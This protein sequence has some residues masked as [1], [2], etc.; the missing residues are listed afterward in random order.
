[1][2]SQSDQYKKDN[3]KT[4]IIMKKGKLVAR[5][6]AL[7]IFFMLYGITVSQA[8]ETYIYDLQVIYCGFFDTPIP[9]YAKD[10]DGVWDLNKGAGG[11][12]IALR[13]KTTDD[14]KN[15]ITDIIVVMEENTT[16]Y[17]GTQNKTIIIDGK[18]YY[19]APYVDNTDGGNLNK[20]VDDCKKNL[21]LYYT[22]DGQVNDKNSIVPGS[23]ALQGLKLVISDSR[24]D[25]TGSY[26]K[27]YDAASQSLTVGN[28]DCNEGAGG[29]FIYIETNYHNHKDVGEKD[30]ITLCD[31]GY[32]PEKFKEPELE[33]GCYKI[34][35][36]WELIWLQD[37]YNEGEINE[38]FN[39]VMTADIDMS[40]SDY[41]RG[42]HVLGVI[43]PFNE[44]KKRVWRG[45][46][47]GNGHKISGSHSALFG[48]AGGVV[49]NLFMEN[50]NIHCEYAAAIAY[51][52]IGEL[53]IKGC[54]VSGVVTG[55]RIVSGFV[56]VTGGECKVNISLSENAAQIIWDRTIYWYL[57]TC[58]FVGST[59]TY[60]GI[61]EKVEVNLDRCINSGKSD[62]AFARRPI[63]KITNCLNVSKSPFM[64]IYDEDLLEVKNCLN[65]AYDHFLFECEYPLAP[66]PIEDKIPATCYIRQTTGDAMPG[67][68][69]EQQ[70][71]NGEAC[72][73]L[74]GEKSD[75]SSIWRQK[76][77]TD[78]VPTP[79]QNDQDLLRVVYQ[80][81]KDDSDCQAKNFTNY[82]FYA[83]DN[84]GGGHFYTYTVGN[85]ENGKLNVNMECN[86]CGKSVDCKAEKTGERTVRIATCLK[87]GVKL[88]SYKLDNPEKTFY[89]EETIKSK[90]SLG[91]ST[92][93]RQGHIKYEPIDGVPNNLMTCEYC[94]EKSWQWQHTK[95]SAENGWEILDIYDMAAYLEECRTR[96]AQGNDAPRATLYTDI[97]L[98]E[99]SDIDCPWLGTNTN[100][101]WNNAKFEGNGHRISNLYLNDQGLTGLF[102][103]MYK[104]EVHGLTV[105]GISKSNFGSLLSSN[106]EECTFE[107]VATEGTINSTNGG[108]GLC[109]HA[110]KSSFIKCHNSA[111]LDV[112]GN[113]VG[114]LVAYA[115]DGNLLACYND[116]VVDGR[117]AFD[118]GGLVGNYTGQFSIN[119]CGSYGTVYGE[120]NIGGITGS[121]AVPNST[122]LS[123]PTSPIS[124][125][126][127]AADVILTGESYAKG[128]MAGIC[129]NVLSDDHQEI[130]VKMA[131]CYYREAQ[132]DIGYALSPILSSAKKCTDDELASGNICL[133]L[134][135]NEISDKCVWHQNLTEKQKYPYPYGDFVFGILY[136]NG[137]RIPVVENSI[138]ESLEIHPDAKGDDSYFNTNVKFKVANLKY[139]RNATVSQNRYATIYMPFSFTNTQLKIMEFDYY[140][141]TTGMV[142]FKEI[143]GSLTKPNVPYLVRKA[144]YVPDDEVPLEIEVIQPEGRVIWP[145]TGEAIDLDSDL[146]TGFYGTYT[147]Y[148]LESSNNYYVFSTKY[149]DFRKVNSTYGTDI[150]PFRAAF[151]IKSGAEAPAKLGFMTAENDS[152]TAVSSNIVETDD[153][154]VVYNLNGQKVGTTL[155]G[156]KTGIYIING[157]KVNI[158]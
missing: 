66:Q 92:H 32:A 15:A 156:L 30:G 54:K 72:F 36:P 46:F 120:R 141:E 37:H 51:H 97:D 10:K 119:N 24:D 90:S 31:C 110:K 49:K 4:I 16:N 94:G 138:M 74:N 155:R 28:A 140:D 109:Y 50:V 39:A 96:A 102:G 71:Q 131:N 23:R 1:M 70:I 14:P 18:T 134:N 114:G 93:F 151:K 78:A 145:L 144:D 147:Q 76:I 98:S 85:V 12:Y 77:G 67:M 84:Q 111:A 149:G 137:E 95:I 153:R 123:S 21:Y 81:T 88:V 34:G 65:A 106:A 42:K 7:T 89:V 5:R 105:E 129:N 86:F 26:V 116:G 13:Y 6:M 29:K 115:E 154:T 3:N 68:L 38:D 104:S 19:P 17:S 45:T 117:N 83:E 62:Y 128:G 75:A 127:N 43:C 9:P 22:R 48:M 73:L 118:V 146:A 25:N 8:S 107:D 100:R 130:K 20:G 136:V 101:R 126:L 152:A 103:T 44:D 52:G 125:S 63:G 124:N 53:T 69:T 33:N 61:W 82:R 47:D 148:T 132:T 112:A 143:D 122:T 11:D 60:P 35:S 56:N 99:M 27:K 133:M 113:S 64:Y 58:G 142:Y 157:K 121:F 158:K 40:Y 59:M 2:D 80:F 150:Y 91:E 87:D 41:I 139:T 108:G 79:I 135:N 57:S 55:N